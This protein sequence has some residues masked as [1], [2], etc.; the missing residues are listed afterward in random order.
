MTYRPLI[1]QSA[2]LAHGDCEELA[3]DVFQVEEDLATVIGTAPLEQLLVV[4]EGCP[5][6]A[7]TVL[8]EDTG[9]QVYP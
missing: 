6:A 5:A 3:P 7:I 1:D 9:E 2:C 4:A 8:D